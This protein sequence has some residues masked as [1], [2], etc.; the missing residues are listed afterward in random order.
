MVSRLPVPKTPVEEL[1]T[2]AAERIERGE[3]PT[4]EA[5]L[6]RQV[7]D[8]ANDEPARG[9]VSAVLAQAKADAFL[10]VS[11]HVEKQLRADLA[12]IAEAGEEPIAVDLAERVF[13]NAARMVMV[14]HYGKAARAP[15]MKYFYFPEGP[16]GVFAHALLI[17]RD[18]EKPF[19]SDFARCKLERCGK[20]F[21][22]SDRV[23]EKGRSGRSYCCDEHMHEQHR[24]TST[25]RVQKH[26][27]KH[28]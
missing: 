22:R 14:P 18:K 25:A 3:K 1:L 7:L 28:K 6:L 12:Q 11:G 17:L 16:E 10:R 5:D 4:S 23:V 24:M 9:A 26:R 2:M 20:F 21:F 13:A 27:A 8:Y 19:R 15:V